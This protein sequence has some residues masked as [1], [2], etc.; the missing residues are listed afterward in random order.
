MVAIAIL[1][2]QSAGSAPLCLIVA[3][4]S[5]PCRSNHQEGRCSQLLKEVPPQHQWPE[6]EE[7][8]NPDSVRSN[9]L[10]DTRN[11][12]RRRRCDAAACRQH[13]SSDRAST[14]ADMGSALKL[15]KRSHFL[16]RREAN[17]SSVGRKLSLRVNST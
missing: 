7:H 5:L 6:W 10:K 9:I 11:L 4:K 12:L 1:P 16:F 3:G 2:V 17:R 13:L 8:E 15:L 14:P